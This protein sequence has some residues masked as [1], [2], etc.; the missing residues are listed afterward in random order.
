[1]GVSPRYPRGTAPDCTRVSI[2]QWNVGSVARRRDARGGAA[3]R[4]GLESGREAMVA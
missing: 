2:A 1:M 3:G 4:P